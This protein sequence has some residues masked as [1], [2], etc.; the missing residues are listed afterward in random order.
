[1]QS[2]KINPE[3]DARLEPT[4]LNAGVNAPKSLWPF[5]FRLAR[6]CHP[7]TARPTGGRASFVESPNSLLGATR[8][9]ALCPRDDPPDLPR[10]KRR[11]E[12]HAGNPAADRRL[13]AP[14]IFRTTI[15]G[16]AGAAVFAASVTVGATATAVAAV[17]SPARAT[18]PS[19]VPA[20]ADAGWAKT[21]L[22]VVVWMFVLAAILGPLERWWSQRH[23]LEK[24]SR[25]SGW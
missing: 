10:S 14:A 12:D 9:L 24:D 11:P 8:G 16:F 22:L 5:R 3:S 17:V 19:A 1:M 7:P 15:R 23:R 25:A 4:R 20:P 21:V 18:G 13:R 6:V 2:D